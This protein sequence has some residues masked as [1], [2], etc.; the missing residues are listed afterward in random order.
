ME[1]KISKLI[2]TRNEGTDRITNYKITYMDIW[3]YLE[4]DREEKREG[5]VLCVRTHIRQP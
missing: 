5:V 4:R 2:E 1:C 3:I